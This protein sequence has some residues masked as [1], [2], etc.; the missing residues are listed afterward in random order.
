MMQTGGDVANGGIQAV[1][2]QFM[3]DIGTAGT[4]RTRALVADRFLSGTRQIAP[5]CEQA[6]HDQRTGDTECLSEFPHYFMYSTGAWVL[7]QYQ[8]R[9]SLMSSPPV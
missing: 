5:A 3:I 2:V 8:A 4:S 1:I 9:R 6:E 7:K